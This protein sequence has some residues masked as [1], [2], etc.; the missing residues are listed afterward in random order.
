MTSRPQ[1]DQLMAGYDVSPLES[2]LAEMHQLM[3]RRLEAAQDRQPARLLA[4][5]VEGFRRLLVNMA[6]YMMTVATDEQLKHVEE[7]F[8][9]T[10]TPMFGAAGVTQLRDEVSAADGL[11]AFMLYT[12]MTRER[13]EITIRTSTEGYLS[14]IDH[15][16]NRVQRS[17]A[18]GGAPPRYQ[19]TTLSQPETSY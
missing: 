2:V 7:D 18:D 14:G 1:V 12:E 6:S 17:R 11:F 13:T 10:M 19:A 9:Q 5:E 8:L 3:V 16:P 15:Q 4:A